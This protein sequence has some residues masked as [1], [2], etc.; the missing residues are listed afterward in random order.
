MRKEH[1]IP[2]I[3]DYCDRW[4]ERCPMTDRCKIFSPPPASPSDETRSAEY[5]QKIW[6]EVASSFG[7]TMELLKEEAEKHGMNWDDMV[8]EAKTIEIVQ[9]TFNILETTTLQLAEK[10]RKEAMNWLNDEKNMDRIK[11][12]ASQLAKNIE[13]GIEQ[14]EKAFSRVEYSLD[15]LFWYVAMVESKVNRAVNGQYNEFM[16][17]ENP[18]QSDANG[19]AKVAV[20]CIDNSM[21]AWEILRSEIPELEDEILDYLAMLS[22][23]LRNMN[24]I[25]PNHDA[26]IR[27]GFD[28]VNTIP[29][30]ET[31]NPR[32]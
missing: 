4:C 10:Y 28:T 27:P 25:F 30:L 6:E 17:N 14:S 1:H 26:F 13:M 9:P 32:S 19:S 22:N 11:S 12:F 15:A 31:Q 3:H 8:E 16:D 7:K 21:K 2:S 23:L 24:N 18:L 5:D 29:V 20:L